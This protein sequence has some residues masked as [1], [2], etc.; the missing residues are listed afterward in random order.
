MLL[1]QLDIAT[2]HLGQTSDVT[3]VAC[4]FLLS[5]V[6]LCLLVQFFLW[7]FGLNHVAGQPVESEEEASTSDAGDESH[8]GPKPSGQVQSALS[9]KEA[10][11]LGIQAWRLQKRI[12]VLPLEDHPKH[13]RKLEDSVNQLNRLLHA[14][15]V[16]VEDPAGRVYTDGW[17]AVEVVSSEVVDPWPHADDTRPF[18]QETIRPIVRISGQI[19]MIGKIILGERE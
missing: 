18:V 5:L 10:I 15:D 17:A 14:F 9:G 13:K 6:A 2:D 11:E 1:S 8:S 7:I 16:A 4:V 3:F 12:S 19:V